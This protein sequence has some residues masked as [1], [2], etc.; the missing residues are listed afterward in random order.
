MNTI[1]RSIGAFVVAGAV[2][3]PQ[4]VNGASIL[5]TR[6]SD[7][8]GFDKYLPVLPANVPWLL[9]GRPAPAKDVLPEAGSVNALMLVPQRA[10]GWAAFTSQPAALRQAFHHSKGRVSHRGAVK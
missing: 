2:L 4:A 8:S 10:Q 7:A 6:A 1:T 3:V 5:R 9:A